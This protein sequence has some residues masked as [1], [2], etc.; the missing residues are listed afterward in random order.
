MRS[1]I[2]RVLLA[3]AV[4]ASLAGTA[5]AAGTK[6]LIWEEVTD[7][8]KITRYEGTDKKVVIPSTHEG[9]P[10][11][12][13]GENAFAGSG[14]STVD[15]PSSVKLIDKQAFAACAGLT[16]VTFHGSKEEGNATPGATVIGESA[17]FNCGITTLQL[18]DDVK[19][20]G[21]NAFMGCK[22][23]EV[24][25]L[26]STDTVASGAFSGC[27]NLSKVA[28][29]GKD[30]EIKVAQDAFVLGGKLKE[31]HCQG[32]VTFTGDTAQNPWKDD[33]LHAVNI[34]SVIIPAKCNSDGSVTRTVGCA[35]PGSNCTFKGEK[36]SIPKLSHDYIPPA[37]YIPPVHPDCETWT[38]HYTETCRNCGITRDHYETHAG[39]G[40][41]DFNDSSPTVEETPATCIQ[42]GLRVITKKCQNGCPAT[43]VSQEVIPKETAAHV[44]ETQT[45]VLL[46]PTCMVDGYEATYSVCKNC[47]ALDPGACSNWDHAN[48]AEYN[49]K[50]AQGEFAP[51]YKAHLE[52]GHRLKKNDALTG[53]H[54][55]GE[56]TWGYATE[57]DK[58]GCTKTGTE[59][60]MRECKICG[61]KE[62]D[63]N[64]TR[65]VK[66]LGHDF[67][68]THDSYKEETVDATCTVDGKKTTT[69]LCKRENQVVTVAETIPATGHRY[70]PIS[71]S[72]PGG[73]L[74]EATCTQP[75]K[76]ISS[77]ERCSKCNDLKHSGE[78][79]ETPALGHLWS[80]PVIDETAADYKAPTCTE[81]GEG[82]GTV[83]CTRTG[84]HSNPADADSPPVSQSEKI[85]LPALGHDWGEW[86]VTKE[87]TTTEAGSRE[88]VCK[89]EGCGEKEVREIPPLDSVPDPDDPDNPTDPDKPTDPDN[90]STPPE[91]N[92]FKVDVIQASNGTTTVNRSTAKEGD[93]VIV[94]VTPNTG[95]VLDMIRV[96][97]DS[98]ALNLTDLGG[99]RYRFTMPAS[100]VEVRA[101]YDRGGSDYGSNWTNGFGNSGSGQRS[102]P[103]RTSDVIPVQIQEPVVGP[104]GANER[105]FQDIPIT[106]WA[107]GEINWAS[108]MGYMNG[109]GGRFNPGGNISQQQ[110]WMVLARL[111]GE[112]PGSME[113]ARRW[114][115]LG[116]FADGSSPTGPVK[117]HQLVTALY[118]CARLTGRAG[119]TTAS[120]AGYPDSR[121]VP[122]VAREAFTWALTNGI[123]SGDAEGRL[124]PNQIITRDQFAVILYRYSHRI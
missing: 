80:S 60:A 88:R 117:R 122:T 87:A 43:D 33:N 79:I 103:R 124:K 62:F 105:I 45:R 29:S 58:P 3:A 18:S 26:D 9:K 1:W 54:T 71:A 7:G 104:A 56:E 15:I 118:R 27:G 94:T 74:Q 39:N 59:T 16:T 78:I 46:S 86:T 34:V 102:D 21:P 67:D 90:P 50:L 72:D 6:G 108:Q 35:K 106:H 112:Q 114:A 95:Y 23:S 17:F 63:P 55:W 76:R 82:M 91:E 121:T 84:C 32:T 96:I 68:M 49:K 89:R 44:Y 31:L 81:S 47:G 100:N 36:R 24:I 37:G 8:W 51:D 107:A 98:R 93:S 61:L 14:I 38:E 73:V 77:G 2:W 116:G 25:I 4:I 52:A 120:L 10:V 115:E 111:T 12:Q 13:I 70:V 42:D 57:N 28:I 110:M 53:Q 119:R 69:G 41:H 97:G 5:L 48:D 64:K 66:A 75:G 19:S 85:S 83:T 92:T 99:G 113:E 65:E 20:I 22:M 109:S 30:S 101:T 40:N 11:I 123:I